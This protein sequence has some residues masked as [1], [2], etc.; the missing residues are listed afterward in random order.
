MFSSTE[1]ETSSGSDS[2]GQEYFLLRSEQ[3]HFRRRVVGVVGILKDP[4]S[5]NRASSD[6]REE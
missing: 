3:E 5:L 4:L 2:R 6:G 1:V